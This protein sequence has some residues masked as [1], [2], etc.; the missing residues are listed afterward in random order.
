MQDFTVESESECPR[1]QEGEGEEEE[2]EEDDDEEE[3]DATGLHFSD[4]LVYHCQWMMCSPPISSR[5][6][7]RLRRMCPFHGE[8]DR[9]HLKAHF[10]PPDLCFEVY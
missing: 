4:F 8:S 1:C 6:R 10:G 2:D 3:E 7:R 5:H 9:I